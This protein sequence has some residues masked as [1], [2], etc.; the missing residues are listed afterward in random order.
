MLCSVNF[1]YEWLELQFIVDLEQQLLYEQL[2][3]AILFSFYN[4]FS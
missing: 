4:T 1:I 2:Y 3:V